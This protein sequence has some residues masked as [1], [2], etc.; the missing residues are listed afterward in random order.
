MTHATDHSHLY[1]DTPSEREE[2]EAVMAGVHTYPDLDI[3]THMD[4]ELEYDRYEYRAM[5]G[6]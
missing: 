3:F 6:F 5:G 4:E 2:R 1:D